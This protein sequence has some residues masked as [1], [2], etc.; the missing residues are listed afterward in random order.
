MAQSYQKKLKYQL[1]YFV[2]DVSRVNILVD[3]EE[4]GD[5]S[6]RYRL[7]AFSYANLLF[8]CIGIGGLIFNFSENY[9]DLIYW[10]SG[11][12][13]GIA[14]L[15]AIA[16]HYRNKNDFFRFSPA[17]QKISYS[18][19]IPSR[20]TEFETSAA[21]KWWCEI[22]EF[23]R[24]RGRASYSATFYHQ[25]SETINEKSIAFTFTSYYRHDCIKVGNA[26]N[27][28]LDEMT[29]LKDIQLIEK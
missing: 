19:G 26:L 20:P 25:N 3:Y 10:L 11:A 2:R 18:N 16:G 13:L 14:V 4:N 22:H 12:F 29:D 24:G 1:R 6:L 27:R 5:I 21:N 8:C 23:R 7:S 28:Y 9:D 17:D 15:S